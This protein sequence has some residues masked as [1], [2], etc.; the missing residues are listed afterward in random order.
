MKTL[1]AATIFAC[2]AAVWANQG[3]PAQD[4]KILL[5]GDK[6]PAIKVA[7]YYQGQEIKAFEKGKVYVVEFWATWCGPCIESI[8][9]LNDLS[10]KLKG[11]AEFVGVNIWDEED[12]QD[13]RISGFVKKMAAKM[14]YRVAVDTPQMDMTSKWMEASYSDGIPTAF[15]INQEGLVAWIGHPMEIETP[16]MQ[17]VEKKFDITA[18]RTAREAE[19]KKQI[20]Q[21]ELL[22]QITGAEELYKQG[23]KDEA[24]KILD[25]LAENETVGGNAK[26]AKLGLYA[27]DNIP[28]AKEMIKS[29]AKGE[30]GDIANL[31]FFSYEQ[32]IDKA[33]NRELAVF[34]SDQI[35]ENLKHDD[36]L[37]LF[38]VAPAYS[39]TGE[40]KKALEILNRALKAF[41]SS[42]YA[43]DEQM[44]SLRKEIENAAAKEKAAIG[45]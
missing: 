30:F 17:V 27:G 35:L 25:A 42:P 13:A 24:I 1:T 43:Q 37:V 16:L 11:K 31:A 23:K 2:A 12:G 28:A 21:N 34:T 26:M 3:V 39:V 36:A 22:D 6:A 4:P 38:S 20:E 10:L 5:P 29:M 32:A 7:K 9:H 15:I 19:V 45:G 40:H 18:A 41:D 44:K 8:P 14:S 33:G